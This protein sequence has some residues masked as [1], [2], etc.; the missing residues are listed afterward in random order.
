MALAALPSGIATVCERLRRAAGD[1]E[2]GE[3]AVLRADRLPSLLT[4]PFVLGA[5][6]GASCGCLNRTSSGGPCSGR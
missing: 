6:L 2:H 4:T 5:G 3:S 1:A